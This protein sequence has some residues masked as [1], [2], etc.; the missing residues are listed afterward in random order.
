MKLSLKVLVAKAIEIGGPIAIAALTKKLIG[1]APAPAPAPAPALDV[2]GMPGAL[3]SAVASIDVRMAQAEDAIAAH[4][5]AIDTHGVRIGEVYDHVAAS[6][7]VR[8][9]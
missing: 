1:S 9:S 7:P 3:S 4:R 8:V 2:S 6:V 5:V